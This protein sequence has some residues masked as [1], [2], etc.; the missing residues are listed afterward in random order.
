[1]GTTIF[2]RAIHCMV[3][4]SV[5]AAELEAEMRK[6]GIEVEDIRPLM[7]SLEDVFVELTHRHQDELEKKEREAEQKAEVRA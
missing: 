5:S 7:P 4:S 6:Q 2:G 3:Q 1:M